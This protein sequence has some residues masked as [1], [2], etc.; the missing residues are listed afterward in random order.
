MARRRRAR[1]REPEAEGEAGV[2]VGSGAESY[3]A[4]AARGTEA[5]LA[6]ELAGLGASSV[7]AESGA[8]SFR[9]DG[10]MVARANLRLRTAERVLQRLSE[11]GVGSAEDL[12]EGARAIPWEDRLT[13]RTTFAVFA[14]GAAPGLRHTGFAALKVKDAVADRM[15]ERRGARPD[16][17]VRAPAVRVAVVLAGGRARICLDAS[18][19][20]LH[21]RGYRA[22]S[23]EAPVRETLAAA[24]LLWSGWDRSRPLTDPTCGS[25][26]LLVEAAWWAMDRDPGL[27]RRFA[28][29]G[30]PWRGGAA[31]AGWR[32][33]REAS[34]ARASSV[35]PAGLVVG[36]DRDPQAVAAARAN[37]AAAG[38]G[39]R[40]TVEV[41]DALRFV[42]P[43]RSGL[44]AFNPPYGRRIGG[45]P[46]RLGGFYVALGRRLRALSDHRVVVL[47]GHPDFERRF[48]GRPAARLAVRNGDL[49]C[50]LLRYDPPSRPGSPRARP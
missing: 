18:G 13:P 6:R 45:D 26:T 21:R 43:A 5:I 49:P 30:W 38:L 15:R 9:G 35:L 24:L 37:L 29:E 42:P 28:F 4:T 8:V 19:E 40:V 14:A 11:F 23:T 22:V 33:E 41:A 36:G 39:E 27:G 44:V 1:V 48:G 3:L 10:R 12:Y 2:G 20:P 31:E 34:R 17:D 47:A 32:E 7:E 16:V 25:G 46:E 50:R